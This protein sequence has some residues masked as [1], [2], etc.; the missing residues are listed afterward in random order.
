MSAHAAAF[1]TQ[2]EDTEEQTHDT[3]ISPEQEA[4]PVTALPAANV[5]DAA[6]ALTTLQSLPVK[7]RAPKTG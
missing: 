4:N 7:G 2:E 1:E 5:S 3:G 6:S